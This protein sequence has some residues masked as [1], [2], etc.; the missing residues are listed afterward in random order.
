MHTESPLS[1]QAYSIQIHV[2]CSFAYMISEHPLQLTHAVVIRLSN[3]LTDKFCWCVIP[4]CTVVSAECRRPLSSC[5]ACTW[6]CFSAAIRN[7]TGLCCR[8]DA[9][10]SRRSGPRRP[11]VANSFGTVPWVGCWMPCNSSDRRSSSHTVLPLLTFEIKRHIKNRTN[12]V[13]YTNTNH[14]PRTTTDES[15]IVDFDQ[16]SPNL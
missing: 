2:F 3:G 13:F 11:F 16:C 4:W 12:A 15:K 8:V 10:A 5:Q 7:W 6:W 9:T 14:E 1:L